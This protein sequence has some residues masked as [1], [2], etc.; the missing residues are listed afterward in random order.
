MVIAKGANG[1]SVAA[2]CSFIQENY[3]SV[4]INS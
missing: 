4:I 1:R 3:N 2:I